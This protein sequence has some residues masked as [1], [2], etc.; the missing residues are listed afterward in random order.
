MNPYDPPQAELPNLKEPESNTLW[1]VF[2]FG[3]PII[4][5]IAVYLLLC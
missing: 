4:M 2:I 1:L 5:V 3:F